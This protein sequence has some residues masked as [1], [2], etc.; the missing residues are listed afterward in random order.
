MRKQTL[1]SRVGMWCGH[2][3]SACVSSYIL[4]CRKG[5]SNGRDGIARARRAFCIYMGRDK[6]RLWGRYTGYGFRKVDWEDG[7][8]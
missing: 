4:S 1:A 8:A 7:L 3:R 2:A 5:W 6:I